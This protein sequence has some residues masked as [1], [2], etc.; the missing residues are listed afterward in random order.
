[1]SLS[2]ADE[3]IQH[4]RQIFDSFRK[5]SKNDL[6]KEFK[7]AV[8]EHINLSEMKVVAEVL[9][10]KCKHIGIALE[11]GCGSGRLLFNL[12]NHYARVIGS[13]FSLGQLKSAKETNGDDPDLTQAQIANLPFKDGTFDLVLCVRVIQHLDQQQQEEAIGEMSRVLKEGGRLV[14]MTY[15]AVTILCIYKIINNIGLYKIWPRWPLKD[16][17]WMIDDYSFPGELKSIFKRVSFSKIRIKGAVC[18][19]PEIFKF[20]KISHFLEKRFSF[21]FKAYLSLCR[22]IDSSVNNVWPFK[23]LLGRILIEGEKN[24]GE[25]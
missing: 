13:D 24:A 19:E 6:D 10:N 21:V 15:N 9:D 25:T 14:L 22:M 20:L 17:K 18:G 4:T 2:K 11:V 5:W 8:W 12:K 1:M 3:N 16:W 23:Y 7:T